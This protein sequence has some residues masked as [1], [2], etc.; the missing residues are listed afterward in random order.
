MP[1]LDFVVAGGEFDGPLRQ[2]I[3]SLK[4]RGQRAGAPALASLLVPMLAVTLAP[5]HL[6]VPVPLHPRR[7]RSRG[8]NQSALLARA[9]AARRREA[10]SEHAMRRVKLTIPQ[11]DLRA[12]ER[13]HNMEG[14]FAAD[15]AHC[16]RRTVVLIDDVCTTGATLRAAA[17]AARDAGAGRVYAAVLAAA[18][19]GRDR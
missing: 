5:D 17:Q 7:Q 18:Q 15:P 12:E 2:A 3:H 11:V 14:A 9:L 19:P 4:Y 6:L 1:S 13:A 10:V 16:A 8:Y